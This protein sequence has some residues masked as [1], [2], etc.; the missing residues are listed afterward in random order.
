MEH[1]PCPFCSFTPTNPIRSEGDSVGW[2]GMLGDFSKMDTTP[3]KDIS[4]EELLSRIERN[5]VVGAGWGLIAEA[6]KRLINI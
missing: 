1:L 3:I 5:A 6:L 4:T 2:I